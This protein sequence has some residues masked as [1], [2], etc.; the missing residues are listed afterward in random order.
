MGVIAVLEA[1][2]RK[3]LL[4]IEP[5]FRVLVVV[6]NLKV[7]RFPSLVKSREIQEYLQS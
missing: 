7:S 1:L 6:L 5:P 3:P 2:E 4:A